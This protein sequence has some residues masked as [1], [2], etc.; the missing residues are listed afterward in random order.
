MEP[1]GTF[2][3]QYLKTWFSKKYQASPSIKLFSNSNQTRLN[4]QMKSD[5]FSKPL[6]LVNRPFPLLL[7]SSWFD[8]KK[9]KNKLWT[10]QKFGIIS[11]KFRFLFRERTKFLYVFSILWEKSNYK[12]PFRYKNYKK[13]QTNRAKTLEFLFSHHNF[14]TY[15]HFNT[16]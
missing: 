16:Q 10:H 7:N 12:F 1:P 4:F 3:N 11:K 13:N 14:F 9:L 8:T 15:F 2:P 6:S 5:I